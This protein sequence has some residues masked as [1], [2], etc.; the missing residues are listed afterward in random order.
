MRKPRTESAAPEGAFTA[1]A[2]REYAADLH[3]FLRRRLRRPHMADDVMQE[4]FA[5]LIRVKEAHLIRQPKAYLF[6]IAFHVVREVHLQEQQDRATVDLADL[7]RA[8]NDEPP[9]RDELAE[10]LNLQS[11][12]ERALLQLPEIHR[13]LILLCK[14][15]GMTYEEAARETGISVHMVEKHLVAARAKI[16]AMIWDL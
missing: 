8:G 10:R 9:D 3:R 6:G 7:E 13:R 16:A 4:V 5:R 14:R 11:Q 2:F 12:L 15:D 1:R